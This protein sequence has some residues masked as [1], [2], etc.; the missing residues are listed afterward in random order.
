MEQEPNQA[1]GETIWLVPEESLAEVPESH[2]PLITTEIREAFA[3]P[4]K[5]FL[6]LASQVSLPGFQDYL[7]QLVVS[8]RCALL[9]ATADEMFGGP[10]VAFQWWV[11]SRGTGP[12]QLLIEP[13][14]MKID[15]FPDPGFQALFS[16]VRWVHWSEIGCGGGLYRPGDQPT[17]K[18]YGAPCKNKLFPPA[19]SRV[20]G[21]NSC[22]D[23]LI[24]NPQ[25]EA[26][27][28]SHENGKGYSLGNVSDALNWI[29]EELR[30]GREP[31]FD[32]GR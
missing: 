15:E 3:S 6:A 8:G 27:F 26:G 7:Q 30:Q 1:G 11:P 20:F 14:G 21:S 4:K 23:M 17:L 29:F 2:R 18:Q 28:L 31:A 13:G 10:Q 5:Y 24:Y 9:L 25:G 16:R 12:R 22:G 32:Y 19:T